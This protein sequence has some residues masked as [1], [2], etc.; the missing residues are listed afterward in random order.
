MTNILTD[1]IIL[2]Y[3]FSFSEFPTPEYTDKCSNIIIQDENDNYLILNENYHPE[4]KLIKTEKD[5]DDFICLM[6]KNEI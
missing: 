3:G 6:F 2:K 5:L 4:W 1:E